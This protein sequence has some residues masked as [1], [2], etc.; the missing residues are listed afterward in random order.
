MRQAVR[1][2]LLLSNP[3][4][5]VDLPR[6]QRR[7]FTVF[8]FE[9]AKQFVAAISG[10]KFEVLFGSPTDGRVPTQTLVR[11]VWATTHS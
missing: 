4:E 7:R 9:Q 10:H 2:K 5:D 11:E 8:D 6:Q 1:W 3:A